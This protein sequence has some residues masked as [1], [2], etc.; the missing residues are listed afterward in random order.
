MA[1]V[2]DFF[3]DM[4]VPMDAGGR[5]EEADFE[6]EFYEGILKAHPE[7]V[8]VLM[9]LANRY[10]AAGEHERGFEMDRRLVRLMP[11]DPIIRYNLAC[12][13]SLLGQVDLAVKT[14]AKAIDLGYRG[15]REHEHMSSDPDLDNIRN[16]ERF[17]TLMEKVKDS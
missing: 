5:D 7:H 2:S 15:N 14:L 6:I 9:A 16:D 11:H 13:Y 8:D 3:E 12:S 4:A 17:A 10:T 1:G